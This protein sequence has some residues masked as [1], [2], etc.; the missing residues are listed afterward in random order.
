MC[1][2]YQRVVRNVISIHLV[3]VNSQE[4]KY[5]H[6]LFQ[7]LV[8]IFRSSGLPV[9]VKKPPGGSVISNIVRIIYDAARVKRQR[10]RQPA[11]TS[12]LSR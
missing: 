8:T 12:D 10:G 3:H 5:E 4:T 7:R 6:V 9:Y 2:Y 11:V 1:F